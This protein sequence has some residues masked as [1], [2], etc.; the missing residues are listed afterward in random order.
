MT[1]TGSIFGRVVLQDYVKVPPHFVNWRGW[2]DV[3]R[4]WLFSTDQSMLLTE[5]IYRRLRLLSDIDFHFMCLC[6]LRNKGT[7]SSTGRAGL[8]EDY[9]R[10]CGFK[11]DVALKLGE[12]EA[13]N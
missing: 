1:Q 2:L 9:S 13:H 12:Q 7:K 6:E 10:A 11:A 3:G 5:G 8:Q 4:V